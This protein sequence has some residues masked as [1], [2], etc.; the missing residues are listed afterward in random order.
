[1]VQRGVLEALLVDAWR[2]V[3]L[4]LDG[5]RGEARDQNERRQRGTG[6]QD[7]RQAQSHQRRSHPEKGMEPVSKPCIKKVYHFQYGE[8]TKRNKGYRGAQGRQRAR[9]CTQD[10]ASFLGCGS[11]TT[12]NEEVKDKTENFLARNEKN[13]FLLSFN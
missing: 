12:D 1:M 10:K 4:E 13:F 7:S 5:A 8:R 6:C 3:H 2:I 9:T 11:A